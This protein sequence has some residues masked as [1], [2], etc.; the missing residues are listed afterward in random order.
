MSS[1]GLLRRKS[2]GTIEQLEQRI[3]AYERAHGLD[4]ETDEPVLRVR[5]ALQDL[6][7]LHL[8]WLTYCPENYYSLS[9]EQRAGVVRAVGGPRALCK[10]IM[11]ENTQCDGSGEPGDFACSRY[12]LV[13][14][15]Y[16]RKIDSEALNRLVYGMRAD[17][18]LPK[19]KFH[20]ALCPAEVSFQLSGFR[21]NAICP[22]GMP[23]KVPVI[24]DE[25]ILALM[26]AVLFV[27]GGRVDVKLSLPVGRFVQATGAHVAPV[28]RPRSAADEDE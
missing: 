2:M 6:G 28:S 1:S 4:F 11:F 9:L 19:K 21:H 24:V 7:L 3:A 22:F 14:V 16:E 17:R 8:C 10:S 26:P 12:F 20:L 13:V 15:Q 25:S 18:Q 5:A 27:G 23:A